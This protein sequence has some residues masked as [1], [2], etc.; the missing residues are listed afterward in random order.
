MVFITKEKIEKK[1]CQ[2]SSRS[3]LLCALF[4]VVKTGVC[5]R[6]LMILMEMLLTYFS[7][8]MFPHTVIMHF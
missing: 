4:S 8:G 5:R 2:W 3:L 6:Q 7:R 1:K